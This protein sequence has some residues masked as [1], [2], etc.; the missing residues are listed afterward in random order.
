MP[1]EA[2]L[3]QV[4]PPLLPSPVT[5]SMPTVKPRPATNATAR[6]CQPPFQPHQ[7]MANTTSAAGRLDRHG[8]GGEGER[9]PRSFHHG[10][11]DPGDDEPD[12]DRVV[13]DTADEDDEHS[14]IGHTRDH[15]FDW[16]GTP[17]G[18]HLGDPPGA[19]HQGGDDDETPA[20]D[21][22][23]GMPARGRS[24][25]PGE[26]DGSRPVDRRASLIPRIDAGKPSGMAENMERVCRAKP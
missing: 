5:A 26:I 3:S 7:A 2:G 1:S 19:Q 22:D 24:E 13:V 23:P 16:V 25:E 9:P 8:E 17:S 14:G 18:G 4:N 21:G 6:R 20:L 15:C 12:H 11:G 10:E